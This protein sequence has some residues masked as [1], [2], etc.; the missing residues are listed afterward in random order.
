MLLH[1]AASLWF[2]VWG[3]AI[4]QYIEMKQLLATVEFHIAV[5][6]FWRWFIDSQKMWDFLSTI[7]MHYPAW[8]IMFLQ[9]LLEVQVPST[10]LLI[11]SSN[12][13]P[14]ATQFSHSVMSDSLL[15]HAWTAVHQ[16]SLSITNSQSI[17]KLMSIESVMPSNHLVLCHPH[18]LLPSIFPSIKVFSS[19]L[20]LTLQ[21]LPTESSTVRNKRFYCTH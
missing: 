9:Q 20:A 2:T 11:I 21:T 19:E 16:A 1:Q 3:L 7:N 17:L 18:L 6:F 4:L 12:S 10:M 8:I 5:P 13:I 15:P 14:S